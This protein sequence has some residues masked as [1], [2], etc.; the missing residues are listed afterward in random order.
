[1]SC[2]PGNLSKWS[3]GFNAPARARAAARRLT[4]ARAPGYPG[5]RMGL[6][7]AAL[8]SLLLLGCRGSAEPPASILSLVPAAMQTAGP[9]E[10]ADDHTRCL[11]AGASGHVER[12]PRGIRPGEPGGPR[13]RASCQRGAQVRLR[14]DAHER[15]GQVLLAVRVDEQGR[16]PYHLGQSRRIRADHRRPARHRLERGEAEALQERREDEDGRTG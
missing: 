6:Y 5:R 13:E 4:P 2:S 10:N 16:I 7:R 9:G 3:R 1:R 8:A 12:P 14:E 15:A 11:M